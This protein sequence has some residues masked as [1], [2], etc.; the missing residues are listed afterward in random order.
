LL[1]QVSWTIQTS[2]SDLRF[3]FTKSQWKVRS[4]WLY[5]MES[6]E[7]QKNIQDFWLRS[8]IRKPEIL[9]LFENPLTDL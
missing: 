7:G 4:A 8:I 9:E 5:P 1:L 6:L 3:K 2:K